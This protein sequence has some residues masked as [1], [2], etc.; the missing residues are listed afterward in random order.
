MAHC[1]GCDDDY[2]MVLVYK[3]KSHGGDTAGNHPGRHRMTPCQMR[4][5]M[6]KNTLFWLNKKSV[7]VVQSVV[8]SVSEV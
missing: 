1:V 6:M 3:A 2:D 5:N 8:S 4:H 7:S